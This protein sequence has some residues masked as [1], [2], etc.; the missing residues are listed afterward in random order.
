MATFKAEVYAHQKKTDG[1]YNIKIR[2]FHNKKKR[3]LAT[4]WY[5]TKDDLTR[6]MKIKNKT[7]IDLADELIKKYRKSCD[8]L[9][10]RMK[11]MSV[12]QVV[13]HI[14]SGDPADTFD[15]D[16]I[17]YTRQYVQHL[18]DTGHAGTSGGYRAM[19][20]SLVQFVGREQ[21]SIKEVT[22]KFLQNWVEWVRDKTTESKTKT[23]NRA[24]SLYFGCL[25]AMYNRAKME[26]NDEDAGIIRIPFSPFK[27]VDVPK[28]EIPIKRALSLEALRKFAAVPYTSFV[29]SRGNNVHNLAKDLFLLS[30]YLVGIN[31]ADL[32]ECTDYRDG[33]IN[34]QR[35]KTRTTRADH[36]EFSVL[37]PP[38]AQELVDKYRDP[39]GI[40]VFRFYK[41]YPNSR[42]F[43]EAINV[44]LKYIGSEIGI[45][46]LQYYAAR[47]SWATIAVNEA[48]VDKYTVHLA[49]NHVDKALKITDTYI[50]KSWK[51]IDDAN[52]KVLD[53]TKLII[54]N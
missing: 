54:R 50:K 39:D 8:Q 34:Y 16:I 49:L 23:G 51:P 2:V 28:G 17:E 31:S 40:R 5:V 12:D 47:H 11:H 37:I 52:R 33:R 25:C 26:F 45:E 32:Y 36:A 15:I 29:P 9:G 7:Y 19:S 4:V 18:K 35:A 10:E 20:N 13:A 30:F 43:N 22:R 21:I 48:G 14:T 3:Y 38:E 42:K 27:Y 44:G 46:N 24:P 53:Y 6:S 41:M 1:T